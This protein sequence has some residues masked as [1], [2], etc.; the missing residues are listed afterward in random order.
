[1]SS[2]A[3]GVPGTAAGGHCSGTPGT[4]AGAQSSGAPGTT[5]G[6]QSSGEKK[7]FAERRSAKLTITHMASTSGMQSFI[8]CL[9]EN[10]LRGEG[11]KARVKIISDNS[12]ISNIFLARKCR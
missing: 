8:L 7:S 5:A 9:G 6:G 10:F 11:G 4:T 12:N 3:P 2:G 1:M